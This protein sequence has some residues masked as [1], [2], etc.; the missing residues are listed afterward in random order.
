MRE[1]ICY[2]II[3]EFM[4][5]MS[6]EN[7]NYLLI[8]IISTLI[9]G[10]L[11]VAIFLKSPQFSLN[12]DKDS[13]RGESGNVITSPNPTLEENNPTPSNEPT[14]YPTS[15]PEVTKTPIP[16]V[17]PPIF[18]PT[19]PSE[20]NNTE[21]E[22]SI[23]RYFENGLTEIESSSS[24]D[25]PFREKAKNTFISIVD[26]IF[27]DKEI[28]GYTFKGLTNSAKIKVISLALKIDNSIDQHFPNYKD[29]IKDKYASF[30]GKIA[31]KYLEVTESLCESVGD[32]TCNQAKEDFEAMKNSFGFTWSLLKELATAGKEKISD[33]YLNWRNS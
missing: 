19:P 8:G 27:Y 23:V 18:V 21:G 3:G 10:G 16:T 11:V 12:K 30:K 31:V 7:L 6:S 2:N 15:Y 5:K 32:D 29:K 17:T 20:P 14:N 33:F 26:F 22:L 4:K 9:I 1:N 25:V 24:E 13:N 28:N